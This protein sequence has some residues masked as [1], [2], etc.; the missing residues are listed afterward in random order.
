VNIHDPVPTRF[1]GWAGQ[2]HI[3][4]S[5]GKLYPADGSILARWYEYPAPVQSLN[6]SLPFDEQH[7]Q[8]LLSLA[9]IHAL[10]RNEYDV[11]QDIALGEGVNTLSKGGR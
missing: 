8:R 3:V 6:D 10:N 5:N 1:A 9:S 4:V 7:H 11:T 2:Y